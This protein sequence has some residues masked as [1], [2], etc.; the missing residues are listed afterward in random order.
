MLTKPE[1]KRAPGDPPLLEM[2]KVSKRYPGV[3]ALDRM[4]FTLEPGEVHVL[5]GENGAGKSTMISI[6]AGAT[7][8]SDGHLLMKGYPI[9]LNS[10]YEA[11]AVGIATVFQE[12]SLVPS[13]S[14][15]RLVDGARPAVDSL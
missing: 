10:V 5:F 2:L 8:P 6:I 12:F 1:Y 13:L 14:I 3:L 15:E 9:H 4:N 7:Q 11:R